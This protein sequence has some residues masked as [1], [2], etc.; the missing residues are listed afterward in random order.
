VVHV[1]QD[2]AGPAAGKRI[3]LVGSLRG[4]VMDRVTDEAGLAQFDVPAGNYTVRAYALG[5]PGPGREFIERKVQV[6]PASESR[7]ELNDCTMC[8]S[9]AH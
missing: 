7:V 3:E 2:W 9:P 8:G 5:E 4:R 6:Q 1:T